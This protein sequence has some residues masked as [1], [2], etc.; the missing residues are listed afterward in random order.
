MNKKLRLLFVASLG[1][2][3]H[4]LMNADPV[5]IHVKPLMVTFPLQLLSLSMKAFCKLVHNYG[6]LMIWPHSGIKWP[7]NISDKRWIERLCDFATASR[8]THSSG[9]PRHA[10]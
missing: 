9:C 7:M 4:G 1:N 2:S 5:M 3:L 6:G 8:S 10:L